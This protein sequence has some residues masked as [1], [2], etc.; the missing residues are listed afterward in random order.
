MTAGAEPDCGRVRQL[1]G[2]SRF[3][4]GDSMVERRLA[5]IL[6]ADMVGYSRLM[7]ADEAGTLGAPQDPPA[8]ANRSRHLETTRAHH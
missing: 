8:G 3:E 2:F 6:A 1:L 5:A 7:E 4:G